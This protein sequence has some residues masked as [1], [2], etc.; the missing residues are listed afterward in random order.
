MDLKQRT[1]Q[2]VV[3]VAPHI[4]TPLAIAGTL[5]GGPVIG[6]AVL[7]AGR[8]FK[9]GLDRVARYQYTLS[10]NW[11]NPVVEPLNPDSGAPPA[12]PPDVGNQ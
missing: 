3:T 5:A 6:A 10:G 8:L 2:Q 1:Y 11:D 4:G 12:T 7:L 9:P